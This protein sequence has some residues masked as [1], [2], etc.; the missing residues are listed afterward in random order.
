MA[1]LPLTDGRYDEGLPARQFR[2]HATGYRH[3]LL[4]Q[5]TGYSERPQE[6]K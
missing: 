6:I 3:G 2:T 1:D 4:P 5:E